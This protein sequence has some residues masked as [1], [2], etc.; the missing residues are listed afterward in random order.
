MVLSRI[1]GVGYDVLVDMLKYIC[2]THIVKIGIST[3]NKN[4]PAG[5]FWLD[6][7]YDRTIKLLEINSARQDSL[8]RS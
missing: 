5:K 7:K 6:G 3:E 4:L 1:L 8:D 2:P